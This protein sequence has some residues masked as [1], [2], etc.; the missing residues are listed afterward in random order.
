V[1][2][3]TQRAQRPENT[4]LDFGGRTLIIGH[5]RKIDITGGVRLDIT[6]GTFIMRPGSRIGNAQTA[7]GADLVVTTTGDIVMEQSVRESR[8]RVEVPGTVDAGKILFTAGGNIESDGELRANGIAADA[9]GGLIDLE[10]TGDVTLAGP[11]NAAGD[12]AGLGG[13]LVVGADGPIVV[14]APVDCS[15]GLDGGD[16]DLSSNASVSTTEFLDVRGSVGG[17]GGGSVAIAVDGSITI[18]NQVFAQGVGTL[19]GGGGFGGEVDF[20]AGGS[21]FLNDAVDLSGGPPG[22]TGGFAFFGADVDIIQRRPVFGVGAGG[23]AT[24]GDISYTAGRLL[25]LEAPNDVSASDAGGTF[26]GSARGEIQAKND[27]VVSG[28]GIGGSAGTIDLDGLVP[29]VAKVSGNITNHRCAPRHRGHRRREHHAPGLQRD[30]SRG[31][32]AEQRRRQVGQRRQG[33]RPDD[34]RRPAHGQSGAGGLEPPRVPE[35]REAARAHGRDDR[36]GGDADAKPGPARLPGRPPLEVRGRRAPEQGRL[37]R[38]QPGQLRRLLRRI[39]RRLPRLRGL[40]SGGGVR[41][42]QEGVRR[43]V[44]RRQRRRRRR[45]YRH[46]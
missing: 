23:E 19:A 29:G 28:T 10:A 1:S 40:L 42:R 46:L 31:R 18:G 37:R 5:S 39:E 16:I 45:L 32:R 20:E 7:N 3:T 34:H 2:S 30:R 22:G 14:N 26:G 27:V 43:R 33:E 25:S 24:G 6:A 4:K 41:Q 11:V 44:R 13:E 12:I 38:R 8:S 35:P 9:N 36:P 15:G 21:I 17:S